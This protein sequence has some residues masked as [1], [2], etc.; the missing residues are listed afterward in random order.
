M[1]VH[2][3]GLSR[4]RFLSSSARAALFLAGGVSASVLSAC[5]LDPADPA[6][7]KPGEIR[8]GSAMFPESEIIARIWALALK[9]AGHAVTVVP[10]IGARD[11]YLAALAEGSIDI[12]PEYSGN[13]AS[14]YGEVSK[15]AKPDEV[16]ATL[17]KN[18]PPEFEVVAPAKAESKDAYRMLRSVAE[19]HDIRSL[20][21]V[22]QLLGDESSQSTSAKIRIGGAPELAQQ[23]YGPQGLAELYGVPENRIEMVGYGDSGGPLTIRALADGAVDVADIYTTTPLRDTVGAPV[24]VVTLE[25]PKQLIPAQ[26][27]VA[28]VRKGVL[29]QSARQTLRSVADRMTTEDLTAMNLRSSGDEKAGAEL[30]AR[31]WLGA[32]G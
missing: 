29:D 24:D 20:A 7:R 18:I 30:I 26:N 15:G 11:V 23:P 5:G 16:L 14:Y 13:L 6:N 22:R 2:Q 32:T 21:D 3:A 10:Q 27:V 28:L 25:D 17:R 31:D 12:V 8:I 1:N 9:D 4:R 19:K